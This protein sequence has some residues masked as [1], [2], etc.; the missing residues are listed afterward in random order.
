MADFSLGEGLQRLP[1]Q[2]KFVTQTWLC[3]ALGEGGEEHSAISH[4]KWNSQT[5]CIISIV[6]IKA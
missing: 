6:G 2:P 5:E 1:G 4:N 3:R